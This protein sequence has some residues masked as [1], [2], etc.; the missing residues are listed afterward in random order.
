MSRIK[1]VVRVCVCVCAR[2][3]ARVLGSRKE[4]QSK[5]FSNGMFGRDDRRS[6]HGYGVVA[7]ATRAREREI[8]LTSC[9]SGPSR[10]WRRIDAA[11]LTY[12][13]PVL[14]DCDLACGRITSEHSSVCCTLT[15]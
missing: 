15:V 2:E 9:Q 12:A 10:A 1:R 7:V 4:F 14:G 11:G 3:R 13:G 6:C 5:G 8:L